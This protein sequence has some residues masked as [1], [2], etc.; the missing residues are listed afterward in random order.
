L[1]DLDTHA[2]E[3]SPGVSAYV[4]RWADGVLSR[5]E[6][7]SYNYAEAF[8]HDE[9]NHPASYRVIAHLI[10]GGEATSLGGQLTNLTEAELSDRLR[11]RAGHMEA[12]AHCTFHG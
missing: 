2:V 9:E 12:S 6:R 1:I 8:I 10:G 5:M 11:S 3:G 7:H 4:H